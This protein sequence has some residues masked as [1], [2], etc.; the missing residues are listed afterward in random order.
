MHCPARQ[1]GSVLCCRLQKVNMRSCLCTM[2]TSRSAELDYRRQE[3]HERISH[4]RQDV[5]TMKDAL[6]GGLGSTAGQHS[7]CELSGDSTAA[8][9]SE[10]RGRSRAASPAPGERSSGG[11]PP[12]VAHSEQRLPASWHSSS[13]CAGC[14]QPRKPVSL[15]LVCGSSGLHHCS[16]SLLCSAPA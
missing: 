13:A 8:M 3:L 15:M 5:C 10:R 12:L 1:P 4:L 11:P 14:R 6:F 7:S 9:H 2:T 16:A